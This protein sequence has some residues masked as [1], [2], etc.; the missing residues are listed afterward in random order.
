MDALLSVARRELDPAAGSVDLVALAR[1]LDGVEVIVPGALPAA[2]G[3]PELVRR[4]LAPLV[5]NARRHASSHVSIELSASEGRV[6]AAVRDDGPGLDPAL[7]ERAFEPGT[8]GPGEPDGGAGLGLALAR[9]L[10]RSCG[11]D[12]AAGDGP[13]GSFVLELP[14]VG[15]GT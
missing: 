5:E 15:T 8:R 12:V 6:R 2:E 11:G 4:A 14:A 9:R 3:E 10:A 13:G 1:E 7:G